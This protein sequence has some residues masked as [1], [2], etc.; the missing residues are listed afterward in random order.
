MLGDIKVY[1]DI[2]TNEAP[3]P[4]E[5]KLLDLC[6]ELEAFTIKKGYD[7]WKAFQINEGTFFVVLKNRKQDK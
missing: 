5:K 7:V 1:Y 4:Y 3:D 6:V 2:F